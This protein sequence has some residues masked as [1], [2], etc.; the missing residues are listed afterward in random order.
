MITTQYNCA[1]N[2]TLTSSVLCSKRLVSAL[3][4]LKSAK[5]NS[6][7]VMKEVPI[8]MAETIEDI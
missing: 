7:I 5:Q 8:P 2:E 1:R 6:Q 4:N 3:P